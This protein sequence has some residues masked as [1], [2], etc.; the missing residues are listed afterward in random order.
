V[1]VFQTVFGGWLLSLSFFLPA[2]ASLISSRRLSLVSGSRMKANKA[3]E[4]EHP[5]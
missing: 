1:Y 3:A 4:T 5:A 2:K